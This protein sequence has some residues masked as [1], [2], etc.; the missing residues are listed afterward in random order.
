MTKK[1]R[2]FREMRFV[3]NKYFKFNRII[4]DD[5]CILLTSNIK[6]IK[7]SPALVV[8]ENKAVF[9]KDWLV[10]EIHSWE[11][12]FNAYAVKLNRKFFKVYTFRNPF[13]DFCIDKEE[14]FDSLFEIAKEQQKA[15]AKVALGHMCIEI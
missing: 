2:F 5:E 15:N 1:D 11:D 7:G 10:C 4:N 3:S 12:G 13:D 9:L 6:T 14:D 8:G